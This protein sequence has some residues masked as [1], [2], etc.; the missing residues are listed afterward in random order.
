MQSLLLLINR[1]L[2]RLFERFHFLLMR[3][4]NLHQLRLRALNQRR[5]VTLHPILPLL[6][7]H[8]LV[9]KSLHLMHFLRLQPLNRLNLGVELLSLFVVFFFGGVDLQRLRVR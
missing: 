6:E 9:L 5:Q 2:L 1:Q 3:L 8:R 4:L 7:N